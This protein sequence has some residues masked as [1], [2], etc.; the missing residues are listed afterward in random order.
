MLAA[1]II[2]RV[3][4]APLKHSL[5]DKKA[6]LEEYEGT[7]KMRMLSFEKFKTQ[8]MG[9]NKESTA[10]V[11]EGFLK[12]LYGSDVPY[13]TL[14]ADVVEK[15]SDLAGKEGLTVLNFEF[16]EP[17]SLKTISEVPVVVRLTGEQKGVVAL[18][19]ELDKSDKKLMVRRL[20]ITKNGPYLSQ[21]VLTVSAFR[22][23]K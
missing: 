4:I 8:E 1:L 17:T 3:V 11:D 6:V 2:A 9:K 16:S 12:S 19:R 18:L 22:L 5:S 23:E 15:I 20:D 21:C 13:S 10:G 7:Y 14:Q